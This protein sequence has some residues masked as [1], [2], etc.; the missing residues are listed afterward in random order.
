MSKTYAEK[1]KLC[2]DSEN[3]GKKKFEA[4]KSTI[5]RDKPD[6]IE[7]LLAKL[8]NKAKLYQL[9]LQEFFRDFDKLRLG[10]ITE[11]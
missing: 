3:P 8:R 5:Y 6:C 4:L 11:A 9:R 1:F 2:G 10:N 7:D